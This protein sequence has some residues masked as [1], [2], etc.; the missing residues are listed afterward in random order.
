MRLP[1]NFETFDKCR[2]CGVYALLDDN[3]E[4]LYIGSSRNITQRIHQHTRMSLIPFSQWAILAE[5]DVSIT[6]ED[7]ES[8][9]AFYIWTY[10]P[11]HNKKMP[12]KSTWVSL[13]VH[14]K[15]TSFK[16]QEKYSQQ[17]SRVYKTESTVF[18]DMKSKK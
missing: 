13:R 12:P 11:L 9:E 15:T 7:L 16:K 6:D 17:F 8:T 5:R 14:L 10:K 18:V 1:L 3:R 4:V 2:L